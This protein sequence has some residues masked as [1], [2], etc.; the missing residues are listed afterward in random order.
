[1]SSPGQSQE[2]MPRHCVYDLGHAPMPLQQ[3]L[4]PLS[5]G[6]EAL[7]QKEI[8]DPDHGRDGLEDNIK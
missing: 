4:R 5:R 8:Q 7:V 3:S 2:S 1:V 6:I